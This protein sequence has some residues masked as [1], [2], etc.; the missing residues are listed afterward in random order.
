M[1]AQDKRPAPGTDPQPTPTAAL[2]GERAGL[3]GGIEQE[4]DSQNA[5][6]S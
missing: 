6:R 5:R 4:M 1:N 3:V 2:A